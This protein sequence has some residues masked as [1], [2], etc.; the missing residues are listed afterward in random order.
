MP[1]E[2]ATTE[3]ESPVNEND[4]TLLGIFPEYRQKRKLGGKLAGLSAK[5]KY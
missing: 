5:A 3:G 4:F 2:R 1:L